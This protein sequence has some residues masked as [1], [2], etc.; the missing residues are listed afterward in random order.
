[1]SQPS[2]SEVLGMLDHSLLK[3]SM[4]RDELEAGCR[5]AAELDVASVCILPY[6]LER[7]EALLRGSRTLLST[8]LAFP[9]GALP[10]AAKLGELKVA[11]RDGAQEV[12]AV[13]NIS[14]VLSHEFSAVERE[15]GQLTRCVHEHGA[16]I[17]IIFE[18]CYLSEAQKI[19]LCEISGEAGVD[20]VK[21]S[22]G[23]GSHGATPHDVRLLRKHSPPAVQV[24]ASG[25]IRTLDAVLEYR[26]LGATRIGTSAS[27]SIWTEAREH[28]GSA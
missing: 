22:T 17:K 16:R 12:D 28:L 27:R 5:E 7:A 26:S 18:T 15:I 6:F 21:T 13:V 11:L 25:G 24:K 3:P 19:R 8:T 14:Q 4:T 23:F 1:M 9:H 10:L 2:I 20:W